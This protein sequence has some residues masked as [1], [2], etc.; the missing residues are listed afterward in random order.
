MPSYRIDGS[1]PR[2]GL[3]PRPTGR[4]GRGRWLAAAG[5]AALLL[6]SVALA[7]SE[8]LANPAARAGEQ[9]LAAARARDVPR[10]AGLMDDGF[11]GALPPPSARELLQALHARI[12]RAFRTVAAG[13]PT[14]PGGPSMRNR[15]ALRVEFEEPEAARAAHKSFV[16]SLARR[17]DGSW[18]V[19]FLPTYRSL[20]GSLYGPGADPALIAEVQARAGPRAPSLHGWRPGDGR[21]PGR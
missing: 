6:A 9:F 15:Y 12:P 4:E 1:S 7:G 3:P 16:V 10:L 2:G 20:L 13:E 19:E 14:L 8:Y 18:R 5:G 17:R 11:Q 21:P